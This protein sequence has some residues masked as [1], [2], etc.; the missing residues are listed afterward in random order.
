MPADLRSGVP[1]TAPRP[2]RRKRVGWIATT[3]GE[4]RGDSPVSGSAVAPAPPAAGDGESRGRMVRPGSGVSYTARMIRTIASLS[5][6]LAL[7]VLAGCTAWATYPPITGAASLNNP[8]LAP[9]PE[10][11]GR[12]LADVA[13][14]PNDAEPEAIV[15]NLPAKIDPAVYRRVEKWL[16]AG[17][18]PM[19]A[20]DQV[21][22]HVT[23]IRVRGTDAEVDVVHR[24]ASVDQLVTIRFKQGLGSGWTIKDRRPWRIRVATPGP[25][26]ADGT[27]LA[28]D[29]DESAEPA[30]TTPDGDAP[31]AEAT[32]VVGDDGDG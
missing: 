28:R 27:V 16:P 6:A 18:S 14:D 2:L 23:A 19:V 21:A 11:M 17:S 25:H 1:P 20:A 13:V 29:V 22:V 5:S 8:G 7:L 30:A 32:A 31:D 4:A 10:L 12:A 24:E 3:G 26:Y 15:F 9:I